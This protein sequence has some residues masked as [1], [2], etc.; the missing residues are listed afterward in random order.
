MYE[1]SEDD[2]RL[3]LDFS[4]D[5]R[6]PREQYFKTVNENKHDIP[7]RTFPP[8]TP[9]RRGRQ[10]GER[11]EVHPPQ[12]HFTSRRGVGSVPR[13]ALSSRPLSASFLI[14]PFLLLS[15]DHVTTIRPMSGSPGPLSACYSLAPPWLNLHA[16]HQQHYHLQQR[17]SEAEESGA[18]FFLEPT[19]SSSVLCVS[20]ENGGP[21][22]LAGGCWNKPDHDYSQFPDERRVAGRLPYQFLLIGKWMSAIPPAK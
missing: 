6:T 15:A 20:N 12:M 9:S 17:F 10:F 16:Y 11:R 1:K 14:Q 19:R 7:S 3:V 21:T 22:P 18:G 5:L 13:S 8:H 4:T 2:N